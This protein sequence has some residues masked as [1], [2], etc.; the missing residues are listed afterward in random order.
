MLAAIKSGATTPSAINTY[1]ASNSWA[2]VTK[3]V[4]FLPNGNVTGGT[5]YVYQVQSGKIVQIGRPR[6]SH[7]ERRSA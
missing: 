6:P 3:T 4:K 7:L 1:L 2:G 5:I